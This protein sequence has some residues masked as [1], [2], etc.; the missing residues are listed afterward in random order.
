MRK[1]QQ[2]YTLVIIGMCVPFICLQAE[3]EK[4][5]QPADSVV[6][7]GVVVHGKQANNTVTTT[8]PIRKLTQQDFQ[9]QGIT[10]IADAM[11]RMA[12]VTL[13]DYGG[14]GGLKSISVRGM[15]AQHTAVSYDGVL[16]NDA[17]NGI[18]DISRYSLDNVSALALFIGDNADI[19]IPARNAAAAS[20]LDIQTLCPI[21]NDELNVKLKAGSFGLVSPSARW[22]K[23]CSDRLSLMLV[24]EY[25]RADN[26]YPYDV[27]NGIRTRR[28]KRSNSEIKNG[29]AEAN[30]VWRPTLGQEVTAKLYY[31]GNA[32]NLPGAIDLY[33]TV[34]NEHQ[35]DK[36]I[37]A[38]IRYKG[39]LSNIFSLLGNLKW[40]WTES[41]YKDVNGIYPGGINEQNYWQREY[42]ASAALL[43]APLQGFTAV[44]AADYFYNELNSNGQLIGSPTR[45]S[46]LQSLS[47]KYENRYAVLMGRALY[48][49][50]VNG[51]SGKDASA[52]E[53]DVSK[54]TMARD[55]DRLSPSFSLAIYPMG[56]RHLSLRAS[57]KE[58]FRQ[59]T[60][61]EN[62]CGRYMGSA[63]L[64]P[65]N[66]RQ[67]NIGTG[68]SARVSSW[69]PSL[70]VSLD[71]YVNHV[72]DK[73]V[74]M[75][76]T[77]YI[78]QYVNVG[79]VRTNGVD[80]MLQ[81]VFRLAEKQNI[82][83]ATNYSYQNAENRTNPMGTTYRKQI[84]YIPK[85]SGGWSVTWENPWC[86]VVW[87]ATASGERWSTNGEN[88][89]T[90]ID[91]YTDM[92]LALY[93]DLLWGSKTISLRGDVLNIFDKQYEVVRRYPMPGRL[94]KFTFGIKF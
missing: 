7:Q 6:M 37:F 46:L 67:W 94:F 80:L 90:H 3:N 22:Q 92:G 28:E 93:R 58:I 52:S 14:A 79:K 38:Q 5:S 9:T 54:Q 62:Y 12:G 35:D 25:L 72:S 60:F 83:L 23:R 68:Y 32:A 50:Y 57:Y 73:I 2:K 13:R 16:L 55:I 21:Q 36:N 86:N 20:R 11:R 87:H 76:I 39:R 33:E 61:T 44:Y 4:D 91:A 70:T 85:N 18:V 71:F 89:A 42:Y 10:D 15:G 59:P 78:W 1:K 51:M 82:Q 41:L 63:V 48:S 81:A 84:A 66:T 69:L 47:L 19:F 77:T 56:D 64:K 53:S 26:H 43:C 45:N 88:A 65:E 24:G 17:Q 34:N 75:P 49:K 74:A 31:Y 8:S 29:H 27:E 30:L 40:N